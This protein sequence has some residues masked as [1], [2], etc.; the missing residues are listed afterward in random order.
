MR[1]LQRPP[2]H[3]CASTCIQ[4]T[5]APLPSPPRSPSAQKDKSC[6]LTVATVNITDNATNT[7]DKTWA[8]AAKMDMPTASYFAQVFVQC[9]V[10]GG[11]L[12]W[13]QADSTN[14]KSYWASQKI[15]SVTPAMRAAVV[16]G[17]IIGP[18]FLAA[19]FVWD[20]YIKK[21]Q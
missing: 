4:L 5:S 15:Q 10:G 13:C 21:S 7:W 1:P 20:N 19:Y 3:Q 18:A 14:N 9:D 12:D 17:A 6:P 2:L 8:A 16:V 11:K